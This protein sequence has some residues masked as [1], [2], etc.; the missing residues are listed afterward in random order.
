MNWI[1]IGLAAL[2]GA[3]AAMIA[4]LFVRNPK[5]KRATYAVVL[6]VS[7]V[8]LLGLSREFIFPDLNAWNQARKAESALLEIPA[9]Q[10]IKQYYPKTYESL[11]SDFQGSLRKGVDESQIIGLVRGH[12]VGLVLKRLPHASDE[13]VASYMNVMLTEIQ[14]LSSQGGDLCYRFL[15]PQ[16][17]APLDGRQYLSKQ[18]R[19]A[20]LAA[21]DQVIRTS[22]ESP[23]TI[24][25]EVEVMPKLEPIFVELANEYGNDI[26]ML[27]N[28]AAPNVDRAKVCSMSVGLYSRILKLPKNESGKIL[29]FLLSQT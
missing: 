13:A 7:L 14:E 9:Y 22:A 15:F 6:V 25:L 27:Q 23:Q 26:E 29:R 17:S 28:P 18:T 12:M 20:D 10:A 4:S 16:Q 2:S 19:E 21:L 24:P 11:L 5:E 1:S 3:L 8:G